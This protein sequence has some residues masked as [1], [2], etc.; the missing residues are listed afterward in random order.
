LILIDISKTLKI[1][2]PLRS[3]RLGPKIGN[4]QMIML[5]TLKP[6]RSNRN[7]SAQ[8]YSESLKTI[9]KDSRKL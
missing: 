4:N 7:I 9:M 5:Q 1:K 6:K 3:K 8:K 2:I